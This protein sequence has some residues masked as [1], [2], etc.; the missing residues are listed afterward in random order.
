MILIGWLQ[1]GGFSSRRTN[2]FRSHEMVLLRMARS[3][4]SVDLLDRVVDPRTR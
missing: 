2:R 3:P 1:G 4:G